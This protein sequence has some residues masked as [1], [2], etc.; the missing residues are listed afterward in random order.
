MNIC[1]KNT[2][3]FL[4]RL[5]FSWGLLLL[6]VG[7]CIST[8]SPKL[9]TIQVLFGKEPNWVNYR[10]SSIQLLSPAVDG[11]LKSGSPVEGT[12]VYPRIYWFFYTSQVVRDFF[13]QQY[14]GTITIHNTYNK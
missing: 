6:N 14:F 13:H 2:K 8:T 7:P 9:G 10:T 4:L 5:C 11:F 3:F 1:E 12:V